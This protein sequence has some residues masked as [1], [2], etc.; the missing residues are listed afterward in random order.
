MAQEQD[1]EQKRMEQQ[2][3]EKQGLI[4]L[5]LFQRIKK[6]CIKSK[7]RSEDYA[8]KEDNSVDKKEQKVSNKSLYLFAE[9]NKLRKLMAIIN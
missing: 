6:S 1:A 3:L 4:K 7:E 8:L 5:T 2:Q 9:D